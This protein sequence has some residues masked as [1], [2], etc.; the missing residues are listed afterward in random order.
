MKGPRPGFVPPGTPP[1]G[2]CANCRHVRVITNRRG[3]TFH[4]C[5]RAADDPRFPRYPALPVVECGGWE[6]AGDEVR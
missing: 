4:L 2:L 1:A 5:R 6:P 3:S